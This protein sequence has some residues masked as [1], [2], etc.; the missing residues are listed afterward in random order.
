MTSFA[1]RNFPMGLTTSRH[2]LQLFIKSSKSFRRAIVTFALT[3]V[4]FRKATFSKELL[5][6]STY[7]LSF[8]LCYCSFWEQ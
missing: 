6:R 8:P 1:P 3:R 2:Q 5:F 7:S 4:T